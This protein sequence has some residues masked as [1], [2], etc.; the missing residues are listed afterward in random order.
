MPRKADFQAHIKKI[1]IVNKTIGGN[2]FQS[3]RIIMEDIELNDENL[4]ELRQFRPN[5]LIFTTLESIQPTLFEQEEQPGKSSGR[6][7]EE[8]RDLALDDAGEDEPL[9][10]FEEGEGQ[11]DGVVLKQFSFGR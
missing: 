7:A 11:V 2:W 4:V 6:A 5:E 1:E 3:I 9:I 8:A 10:T